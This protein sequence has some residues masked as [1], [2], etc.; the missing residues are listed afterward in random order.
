[1]ETETDEQLV[2]RFHR[3]DHAAFET[4]TLRH[5][6]RIF[7]LA[8]IYLHLPQ[9]AEDAAQEVFLRA[10]KG[11]GHFRFSAQPL[12]WLYRALRNVCHEHNRRSQRHDP[13]P[14]D[15]NELPAAGCQEA[16][17]MKNATWYLGYQSDK[18]RW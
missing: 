3:G 15:P 18:E 14:L 13:Y 2:R 10:F 9:E 11:L 7:R 8:S 17:L 1:M 6:D 12:T 5:Q 4:L 16:T